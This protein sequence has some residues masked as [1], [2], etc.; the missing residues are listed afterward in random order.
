MSEDLKMPSFFPRAIGECRGVGADFFQCLNQNSVKES[1]SDADASKRGL[2][3]C[4]KELQNYSKCMEK[5]EK[6]KPLRK[7]RVQEEYRLKS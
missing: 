1:P 2:A 6:E 5:I 3:S 4:Q 7:F